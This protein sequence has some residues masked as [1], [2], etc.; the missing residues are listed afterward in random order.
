MFYEGWLPR[1]IIC[2]QPVN[3]EQC[4][5]DKLGRPVHENCYVSLLAIVE[6]AKERCLR[7]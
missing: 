1:C 4:K 7:N 3:I 5:T 6:A 2:R